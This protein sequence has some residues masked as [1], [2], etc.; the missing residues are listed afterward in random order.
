MI[1]EFGDRPS[2]RLTRDVDEA[3]RLDFDEELLPE[4]SWEPDHVAGEFEVEAI[5]DDR[6][7]LSTSTERAVREF[8]DMTTRRGNPHLISRAVVYYTTISEKHVVTEGCKRSKSLT[9][10]RSDR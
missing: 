4:D 2:D 1:D 5:V 8:K 3:T 9:R 10:T 7:P 6:T